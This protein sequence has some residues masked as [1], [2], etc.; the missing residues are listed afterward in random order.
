MADLVKI[1]LKN[2]FEF[3]ELSELTK[4]IFQ[5]FY[6][7][8]LEKDML[9]YILD[10]IQ[11][12][13]YKDK[14]KFDNYNIFLIE[15]NKK[16]IGFIEIQE[17][18]EFF[19]IQRFYFLKEYR[20]KGFGKEIFKK[21]KKKFNGKKFKLYINEKLTQSIEILEKLG[22]K[23]DKKIALYIGSNFYLYNFSMINE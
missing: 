8:I 13:I 5:E 18:E 4:T 10:F 17:T 2:T 22:F 21:I 12:P 3:D 14:I 15:H 7:P 11:E 23:L 16:T 9:E 1:N 6:T 19:E 20:N